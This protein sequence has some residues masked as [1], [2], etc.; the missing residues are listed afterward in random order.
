MLTDALTLD[1]DL[2]R[3]RGVITQRD[4]LTIDGCTNC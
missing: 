3:Q 4:G 1:D 2:G